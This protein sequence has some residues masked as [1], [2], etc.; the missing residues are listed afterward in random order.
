LCLV[1]D[2]SS[3]TFHFEIEKTAAKAST[4]GHRGHAAQWTT[5]RCRCCDVCRAQVTSLV[6]RRAL[7]FP[8]A[9]VGTF[10]W[11]VALATELPMRVLPLGRLEAVML[12]TLLCAVV[13]AVPLVLLDRSNR[14]LRANLEASWLFRRLRARVQQSAS[15][16]PS[17]PA[18]DHW[19]VLADA[20]ASADVLDATDLLR[21]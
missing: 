1:R 3:A 8:L 20:P 14:S 6:R 18:N 12:T 4:S 9:L 2:V 16:A 10:A 17:P 13:V 15:S 5:V 11:P 19:K 21:T 7:L